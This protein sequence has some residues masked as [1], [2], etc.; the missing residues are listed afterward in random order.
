M[1]IRKGQQWG[2]LQVPDQPLTTVSSDDELRQLIMSARTSG[3]DLAPVG[4]LGGDL[5]RTLG[6]MADVAHFSSGDPIPH[7]PIDIVRVV[8]DESRETY[9]VAHLV[10]RNS[11]WQGPISAAMNAQFLGRWDV[12]P[13]CHPNDGKVDIVHVSSDMRLQQRWMARSRVLLGAHVPHPKIAITQR[14]TTIIDFTK[15]TRL[16]VDGVAWG[17][18]RRI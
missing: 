6:G 5:M 4:L 13:R 18:G 2:T 7:L 16:R 9:F 15:R 14:S 3:Q 1:T 8:S 12:S 11:W 10:A 17:T